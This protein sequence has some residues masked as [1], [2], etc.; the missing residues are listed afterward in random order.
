M[1]AHKKLAAGAAALSV[2]ALATVMGAPPASASAEICISTAPCGGGGFD[3]FQKFTEPGG[4]VD[5]F[6]KIAPENAFQKGTLDFFPG[7]TFDV[8]QKYSSD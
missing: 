5:V 1:G 6:N 8:F 2:V 7:V 3:H 4:S